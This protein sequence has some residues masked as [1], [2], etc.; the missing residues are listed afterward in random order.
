MSYFFEDL[1]NRIAVLELESE[2]LSNRIAVLELES[3]DLSNRIAVLELESEDLSN[4]I[5]VLAS[6]GGSGVADT[7]EPTRIK[8]CGCARGVVRIP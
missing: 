6:Q 5:A 7:A 2:D 1:S 8:S 4:R 3:E